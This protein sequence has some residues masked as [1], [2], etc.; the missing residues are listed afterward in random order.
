MFGGDERAIS[1]AATA[2]HGESE[3]CRLIA[4]SLRHSKKNQTDEPDLQADLHHRIG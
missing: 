2:E 1:R 4:D 3:H